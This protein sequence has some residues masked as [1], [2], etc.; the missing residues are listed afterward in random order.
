MKDLLLILLV[1]NV[2]GSLVTL[3]V[4]CFGEEWR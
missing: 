3:A 2:V 4:V 1:V